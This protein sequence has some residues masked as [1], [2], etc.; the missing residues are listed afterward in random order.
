MIHRYLLPVAFLAAACGG[1]NKPPAPAPIAVVP[2]A[3]APVP[4]A[5]AAGPEVLLRGT[6]H[7]EPRLEFRS[8]ESGT[9]VTALDSTGGR[10]VSTYRLM[11]ASND[12]GMYVLAR[13]A[14]AGNG[15]VVLREIEVASIPT[16]AEGCNQPQPNADIIVRGGKPDW[17][18]TISR[19]G[20]EFSQ[21]ADPIIVL[22][23][24]TPTGGAGTSRYEVAAGPG[25]THTLQLDLTDGACNLGAKSVYAA[26]RATMVLDGKSLS[27]CAWRTRLP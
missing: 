8:C 4:T 1:E 21:G 10:L 2:E 6:V 25:N 5:P 19:S 9:I 17:G 16:A 12:P 18:L 13:G 14:R 3:A 27:G 11:Q 23:A 20:I 26:M 15:G 24:V 7:L 22:P